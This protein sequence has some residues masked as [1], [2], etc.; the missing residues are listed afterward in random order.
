MVGRNAA[1][2]ELGAHHHELHGTIAFSAWLGVHAWLMS[3]TRA[4]IDAFISWAWDWF[5]KSRAPAIID[6]PDRVRIDW[7]EEE[8]PP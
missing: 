6:D 4:R 7:D 3:T 8:D 5:S 2:A 1:V